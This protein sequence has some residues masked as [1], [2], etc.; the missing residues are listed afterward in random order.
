MV[1]DCLQILYYHDSRSVVVDFQFSRDYES[2]SSYCQTR[3]SDYTRYRG[4][5]CSQ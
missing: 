2:V 5:Y 4:K 3:F 1:G